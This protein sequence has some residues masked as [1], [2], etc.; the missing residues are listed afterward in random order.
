MTQQ[1]NLNR[2]NFLKT[3]SAAT[4]GALA[5]GDPRQILAKAGN[6]KIEATA[7]SV[8]VLWMGGGMASTETFDPK[9]YTAYEKGLSPDQVLSTFP[10]IDTAVDNIKLTK[11]LEKVGNVMDRG[12]LIR[13][14]K[15]GDLG[16]ILHSRH[17]YHWHTG[18]APP[19]SVAAPHIG[20]VIA[21]SLGPRDP[22]M[23]AFIDIGQRLDVGEGEELKAF[24]SA[25]F[26]GSEYGPFHIAMFCVPAH[27]AP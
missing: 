1:V 13:T 5:A 8:I 14:Y 21:R 12:T 17:Q 15:A 7:D 19:L 9:R 10:A 26:L 11:G 23:P 3:A 20:A 6:E 2:R 16:F 24:H 25:G 22:A 18:Y 27:R 4:L